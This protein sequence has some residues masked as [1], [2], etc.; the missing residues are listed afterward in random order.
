MARRRTRPSSRTFFPNARPPQ[1]LRKKLRTVEL[2]AGLLD[3]LVREVEVR[4]LRYDER[5]AEVQA[6]RVARATFE[7]FVVRRHDVA[8]RAELR[9]GDDPEWRLAHRGVAAIRKT[10]ADL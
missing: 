3:A 10:I 4:D 6:R 2:R 8:R 9:P 5:E 7:V 1:S